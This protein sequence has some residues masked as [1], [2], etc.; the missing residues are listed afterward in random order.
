MV[1]GAAIEVHRCLGP[2]LLESA[3]ER[4]M[5]RELSIRGISFQRQ[6]SLDLEYKGLAIRG[7]YR[8]D[9]LIEQQLL[10][11]LKALETISEIHQVQLLTY[12]RLSGRRLGL[13]INFNTPILWRG[14]R[15]VVNSL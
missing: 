15:R 8:V 5:C 4:C 3:Y 13:I 7:A 10:V 14:V 11:E 1:I 2:G 12:L 9:L 6:Q